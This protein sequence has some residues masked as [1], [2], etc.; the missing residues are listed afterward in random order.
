MQLNCKVIKKWQ[1]P[2]FYINP[3][4]FQAYPP[5]VAKF[6]VP[7]PHPHPSDSIFGRS[8]FPFN[9]RGRFTLWLLSKNPRYFKTIHSNQR[10]VYN[11]CLRLVVSFLQSRGKVLIKCPL[12]PFTSKQL[13]DRFTE[14]SFLKQ[15][16]TWDVYCYL[17]SE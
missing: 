8:Y 15:I 14:G 11:Q 4:S 7:P 12:K 5:L 6:L 13:P 9:K 17:F 10:L 16:C 3:H 2:H 1:P